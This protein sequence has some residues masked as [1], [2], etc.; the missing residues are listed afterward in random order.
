[1]KR[2][3][4]GLFLVGSFIACGGDEKKPND[5]TPF[6]GVW[7]IGQAKLGVV[8]AGF[9]AQ[10]GALSGAVTVEEGLGADLAMTFS[11]PALAGCTLR[12]NVKDASTAT[13]LRGQ[14]CAVSVQG[15]VGTLTV[16]SGT[17]SAAGNNAALNLGGTA[18]AA[19]GNLPFTCMGT[20]EGMLNRSAALDGGADAQAGAL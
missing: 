16:N 13:P 2:V 19:I 3:L 1:M 10:E 17:F 5:L 15:I 11:D 4:A 18:S 7:N 20:V 9:G 14:N 12:F 6:L 8:C